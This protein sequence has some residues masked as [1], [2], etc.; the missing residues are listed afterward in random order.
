MLLSSTPE[1][2]RVL[3][4]FLSIRGQQEN[5]SGPKRSFGTGIIKCTHRQ[6]KY[7]CYTHELFWLH[8]FFKKIAILLLISIKHF[9]VFSHSGN[10][11]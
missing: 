4:D 5:A 3:T 8:N 1:I 10:V 2:V 11:K 7:V 6:E 9:A